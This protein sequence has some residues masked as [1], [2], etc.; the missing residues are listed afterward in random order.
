VQ[1]TGPA[2]PGP[3]MS[4]ASIAATGWVAPI[5][6]PDPGFGI[7]EEAPAA[8]SGYVDNTSPAAT[9]EGNPLGSPD[10]P[11]LTIPRDLAAGTAIEVHGGPY[12]GAGILIRGAGTADLPVFVRGGGA[13]RPVL[14]VPVEIDGTYVIVEQMDFNGPDSGVGIGASAHHIAIRHSEVRNGAGGP[15]AGIGAGRWSGETDP[16]TAHDV[17]IFDVRIHDNGAWQNT[18]GD[19]DHHGIGLGHH[20]DHVWVLDSEMFHN[21]GDGIQINGKTAGL[22]ATCHHI[23]V[24]RNVA[25]ENKQTGFWTK[26]ATDVVFSQNTSYGHRPSD[27][28]GGGCMGYQYGPERVWFLFNDMRAC[29]VGITASTNVGDVDNVPGTGQDIYVVGNVIHDIHAAAGAL[30]PDDPWAGGA[31]IRFTDQLAVRHVVGNTIFDVDVAIAAAR[32]T[33][34]L[35]IFDNLLSHVA[36]GDVIIET[37]EAAAASTIERAYFDAPARIDWGDTSALDLAGFRAG[38]AG[39]CAG[40]LEGNVQLVDLRPALGS[41]TIDAGGTAP[42]YA[43]FSTLYGIDIWKAFDG[44]ARPKSAGPDIG[45]FE[46]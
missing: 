23:Y 30:D 22:M 20:V 12:S 18:A 32:G 27:S 2:S 19:E 5:G 10:R 7:R 26:Q 8:P 15:S 41:V 9:D 3:S 33:G 39:Q 40:C 21:S 1:A 16:A 46:Q 35:R 29:E 6:I 42:E 43:A 36:G 45:A 11:R 25:Y 14:A 28:S 34:A 4:D 24:G 38:R 44:V 31:A 13:V 17:V 37:A